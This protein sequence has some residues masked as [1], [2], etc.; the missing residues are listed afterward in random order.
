MGLIPIKEQR[1][2]KVISPLLLKSSCAVY[3]EIAKQGRFRANGDV[4]RG[5]PCNRCNINCHL[6][7]VHFAANEQT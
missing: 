7:A 1:P 6:P 2:T 3:F 5:V 4:E